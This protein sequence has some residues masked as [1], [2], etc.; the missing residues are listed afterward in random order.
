MEEKQ[1][2]RLLINLDRPGGL[3]SAKSAL[4][5]FK[6]KRHQNESC[7]FIGPSVPKKFEEE[8]VW[9]NCQKWTKNDGLV[10]S[11]ATLNK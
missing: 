10:F 8:V 7:Y 6:N 2:K 3:I 9:S 5:Q 11:K 1:Y 4:E